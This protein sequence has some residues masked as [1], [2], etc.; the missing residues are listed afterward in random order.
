MCIQTHHSASGGR[1]EEDELFDEG[2]LRD[3][4]V[5]DD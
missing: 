3:I 2:G 1:E 5:L 4:T